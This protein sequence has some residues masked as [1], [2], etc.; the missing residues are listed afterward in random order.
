MGR[1]SDRVFTEADAERIFRYATGHIQG[2]H[3]RWA[4]RASRP[5]SDAE[6]TAALKYEMQGGGGG[7]GPDS[8]AY[9]ID[10]QGLQVWAGWEMQNPYSDKPRWKGA[11]TIAEARR[12]YGIRTP[13]DDRQ[14]S[15][16][17][18]AA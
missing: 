6:L 16:F 8:P 12:I 2:C 3:E 18:E 5:M 17:G 14:Y 9:A 15:L 7:C 11:A 10:P 4:E 13:S 1:Y